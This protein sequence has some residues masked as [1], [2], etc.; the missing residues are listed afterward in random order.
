MEL[1]HRHPAYKTSTLTPE[2]L[3]HNG[4]RSGGRTRTPIQATD[5]KSVVS[6]NS[7]IR[8]LIISVLYTQLKIKSSTSLSRK[9]QDLFFRD[10]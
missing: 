9:C 3:A 4:A 8:A 6:T 2:L 5:F 1:N 10:K 7:T